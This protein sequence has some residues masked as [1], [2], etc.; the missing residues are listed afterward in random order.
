MDL[1]RCE[2]VDGPGEKPPGEKYDACGAMDL[3]S[4]CSSSLHGEEE[5]E[6]D[7]LS[8][9]ENSSRLRTA[10][11]MLSRKRKKVGEQPNPKPRNK[12]RNIKS[13]LT[14]NELLVETKTAQEEE[15]ERLARLAAHHKQR[16][17][18]VNNR[19]KRRIKEK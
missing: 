8:A 13:V 1:P 11:K 14:G 6:K 2:E 17:M 7:D 3:S 12:R 4:S 10:E 15:Q 16:L 18:E 5:G 19:E 9:E